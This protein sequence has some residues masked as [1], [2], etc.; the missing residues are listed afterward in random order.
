MEDLKEYLAAWL[1]H[2]P[3]SL[4]TK[5]LKQAISQV[6]AARAATVPAL[7]GLVA[8]DR[9]VRDSVENK[10]AAIGLA[11]KAAR[12]DQTQP[13]T[14]TGTG[15][16][17]TI[18]LGTASETSNLDD[19]T[20]TPPEGSPG[21]TTH[22]KSGPPATS[23]EVTVGGTLPADYV[24]YIFFHSQIWSV[25]PATGGSFDVMEAAGFGAGNDIEAVACLKGANKGD[26]S[27]PSTCKGRGADV[28][29]Y[30]TP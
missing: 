22:L 1:V 2:N 14:G 30:W 17:L 8:D 12:Q 23:G 21:A 9:D 28:T 18:T 7:D 16:T 5:Q 6:S 4:T 3:S 20:V 24:V 13:T 10:C 25:L 26:Q 29:I 19:N 15:A 11:L 27:L